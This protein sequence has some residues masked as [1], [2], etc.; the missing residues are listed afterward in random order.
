MVHPRTDEAFEHLGNLS[1]HRPRPAATCPARAPGPPSPSWNRAVPPGKEGC[2][3]RPLAGHRGRLGRRPRPTRDRASS[4]SACWASGPSS[5]LR[6]FAP[7]TLPS[8]SSSAVTPGSGSGRCV[9]T[10]SSGPSAV[11][12]E[13]SSVSRSEVGSAQ[14]R[15]SR[16]R[17]VGPTPARREM[18]AR[19]S[20][21]GRPLQLLGAHP[22][23]PRPTG[24]AHHPS[25]HRPQ[26]LV[27][28]EQQS[29]PDPGPGLPPPRPWSGATP[30]QLARRCW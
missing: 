26:V 6:S 3:P 4:P 24:K 12:E 14:C 8:A 5:T 18:T 23:Q 28:H 11:S 10:N 16:A 20:A 22:H 9:K 27:A 17:T 30:T 21:E 13:S 15:S 25:Q 19:M 1:V 29:A 2:P 7:R